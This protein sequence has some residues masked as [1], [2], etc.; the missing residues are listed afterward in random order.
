MEL[1]YKSTNFFVL[2][3]WNKKQSKYYFV[4]SALS[5]K[6]QKKYGNTGIELAE[7]RF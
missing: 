4:P 5:T 6:H 7:I 1:K 3:V 2:S